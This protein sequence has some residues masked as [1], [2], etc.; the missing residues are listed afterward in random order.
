MAATEAMSTQIVTALGFEYVLA[1]PVAN[2]KTRALLVDVSALAA[3]DLVWLAAYAPIMPAGQSGLIKRTPY[4][5]PVIEWNTQS[6]PLLMPEGGRVT[7]TQV[8]GTPRAFPWRLLTI[9]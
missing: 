7:L 9:D 5:G 8:T 3:G 1:S 6:G 4:Y 2:G